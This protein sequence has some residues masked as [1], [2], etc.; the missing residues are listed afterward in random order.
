MKS[1]L[2]S[3][4]VGLIFTVFSVADERPNVV[5]FF[6]DDLDFDEVPE[7]LYDLSRFPSHTGMKQMGYYEDARPEFDAGQRD[8]FEKPQ[9]LMPNLKGLAEDGMVLE[10]FY[11]TSPVCSPS[12]YSLLTGRFASRGK[13]F[14]RVFPA[15]GPASVNW[16]TPLLPTE[17]SLPKVLQ[18]N[19]YYTGMVGKWHNG[20][21]AGAY[22]PELRAMKLSD[23]GVNEQVMEAQRI[24]CQA[25]EAQQGFDYAASVQIGNVGALKAPRE[26]R[27]D[28]LE[29]VTQGAVDFIEAAT[30]NE[31]QKPFFLYV[32]LP[33]PHR[34]YYDTQAR[35]PNAPY[36]FERDP[37]AT[38]GGYLEQVSDYMPSREDVV[39]RCQ[40]AG[41]PMVNSM[42]THVDDSL[43]AVLQKLEEKGLVDNTF[44]VF[45]SDHQ[46]RGKNT[47]GESAR[48]PCVVRFPGKTPAGSRSAGISSNVDLTATI[49]DLAGIQDSADVGRDGQSMLPMLF[50]ELNTCRE[51]LYLEIMYTRGVVTDRYKYIA[52]RA[53]EDV[54][55]RMHADAVAAAEEKRR[56]RIS[57]DGN[58]NTPDNV[59]KGV[60]MDGD[61][62]FPHYFDPDQ[63]YD[64]EA[65]PFEQFNLANSRQHY[66]TLKKMKRLLSGYLEE[67]PHSFGE[68]T[69]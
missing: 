53:P 45:T 65:D 42:G 14:Q 24:E 69:E 26:L 29:W 13:G 27:Q 57:W 40:E 7:G 58:E 6:T 44:F 47:I 66:T 62:E 23:P 28:N 54:E 12:R 37:R 11:M 10:R 49:L 25:M 15:G 19:G 52:G 50:G 31:G 1:F 36:W 9:M 32:S 59:S 63:L 2:F 56:R 68:F 18:A 22:T 5:I 60:V 48:V 51:S 34:Q 41:L 33:M 16:G 21:G 43:G 67:L 46:S 64:L 30:K 55:R 35:N 38:P 39:R 3:L 61:R 20:N 17:T 4:S 8:Y